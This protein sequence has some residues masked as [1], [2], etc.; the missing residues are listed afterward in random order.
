MIFDEL[1]RDFRL[2]EALAAIAM[3]QLG[4]GEIARAEETLRSLDG[5][6]QR[7][8]AGE[9]HLLVEAEQSAADAERFADLRRRARQ[10]LALSERIQL[11]LDN[12]DRASAAEGLRLLK[13]ALQVH[14]GPTV[15]QTS[16]Q[17]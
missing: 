15:S 16:P 7:E 12:D 2:V 17:P 3:R 14:Q 8:L 13:L 11:H 1:W 6:L 9:E 4:D 5:A 10:L